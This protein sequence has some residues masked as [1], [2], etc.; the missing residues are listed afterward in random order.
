V[1]RKIL[2]LS[3][4]HDYHA[5]TNTMRNIYVNKRY[6]KHVPARV[7]RV[8]RMFSRFEYV[9]Q[10]TA[11]EVLRIH[12]NK[13]KKS[14]GNSFNDKHTAI[15]GE[16]IILSSRW[17]VIIII[18]IMYIVRRRTRSQCRFPISAKIVRTLRS[19]IEIE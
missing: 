19:N 6:M 9:I 17:R 14:R 2:S 10:F 11:Y 4:L 15:C 8:F 13:N 16:C 1:T 7:L 18:V 12:G 3:L 5:H